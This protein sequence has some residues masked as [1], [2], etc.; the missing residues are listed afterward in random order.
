MV[1]RVEGVK[2][3]YWQLNGCQLQKSQKKRCIRL[4]LDSCIALPSN[5]CDSLTNETVCNLHIEHI[6]KAKNFT[7]ALFQ[8]VLSLN[9]VVNSL[10][11][12]LTLVFLFIT[13]DLRIYCKILNIK[14]LNKFSID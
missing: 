2:R 14:V 11:L 4:K 6:N 1:A 10:Y 5:P 12:S 9:N 13:I 3:R 7:R 8:P